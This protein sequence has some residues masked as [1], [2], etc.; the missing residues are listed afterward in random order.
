MSSILVGLSEFEF[1]EESAAEDWCLWKL[2]FVNYCLAREIDVKLDEHK[3]IAASVLLSTVGLHALRT[4]KLDNEDDFNELTYDQIIKKCDDRYAKVNEAIALMRFTAMAIK[5]GEKMS[6]YVDRLKVAASIAGLKGGN[7]IKNKLIT[8][9]DILLKFNKFHSKLVEDSNK[10]L[11]ELVE[12]QTLKELQDEIKSQAEAEHTSLNY[13]QLPERKLSTSSQSSYRSDRSNRSD[14]SYKQPPKCWYCNG[15][16]PHNG[17]C[18]AMDKKCHECNEIGHFK[19]C[20]PVLNARSRV[21]R[22]NT[23]SQQSEAVK[24]MNRIERIQ[25]LNRPTPK[26]NVRINNVNMQAYADTG[27]GGN[28]MT[29]KRME[30]L[31]PKPKLRHSTTKL[32]AFDSNTILPIAG[33]F[34][35]LGLYVHEPYFRR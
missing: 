26:Q 29:I 8:S 27:A 25:L 30:K 1:K 24:P 28:V 6:E 16:F 9:R 2:K 4:I 14:R 21:R 13:L 15:P 23:S 11:T 31:N 19:Q 35:V 5:D 3:K 10:T 17:P 32:V 18:Y 33:E 7:H 22:K 20:C 12:W 34:D